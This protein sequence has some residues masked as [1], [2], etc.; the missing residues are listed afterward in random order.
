[1]YSNEQIIQALK[2]A[3]HKGKLDVVAAVVGTIDEQTL[4]EIMNGTK[5][6]D[7]MAKT[8]LGM[9]LETEENFDK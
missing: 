6:L 2:D 8:M 4:R 9:H 1:M 7:M 5:E 3:D